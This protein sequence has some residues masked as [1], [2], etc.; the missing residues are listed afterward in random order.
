M[1]YRLYMSVYYD[2]Q[3]VYECI[4]MMYRLYMSVYYDV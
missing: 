4:C 3:T 1:M 2:V